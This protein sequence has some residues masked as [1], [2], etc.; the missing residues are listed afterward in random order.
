MY[1]PKIVY[2][3]SCNFHNTKSHASVHES[4]LFDLT[5]DYVYVID[6]D[7]CADNAK[8][9]EIYDEIKD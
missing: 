7:K 3:S 2:D 1:I 5:R 9:K 8:D 6:E 4:A